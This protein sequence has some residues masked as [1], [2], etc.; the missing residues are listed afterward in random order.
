MNKDQ[1]EVLRILSSKDLYHVLSVAD[2]FTDQ[3]LLT[4]A[5]K[6]ISIKVHPEINKDENAEKAFKRVSHAYQVLSDDEKR[7]QYNLQLEKLK[8]NGSGQKIEEE[9]DETDPYELYL[10]YNSAPGHKITFST[11]IN[12]LIIGIIIL[13]MFF[14]INPMHIVNRYLFNP[15]TKDELNSVITFE[16]FPNTIKFQTQKEVIFYLPLYW[17][18]EVTQNLGLNED[19][20]MQL[21]NPIADQIYTERLLEKCELEKNREDTDN[22]EKCSEY[23]SFIGHS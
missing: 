23:Y 6:L 13:Q 7:E 22:G 3:E 16:P 11:I 4:T 8:K 2:D 14:D 18:D 19:D 15:I 10:E 17:I 21:I 12:Y 20:S 5:Y 1:N 9:D